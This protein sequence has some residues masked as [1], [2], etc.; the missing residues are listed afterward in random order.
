MGS[1]LVENLAETSPKP[2][3]NL[4]ENRAENLAENLAENPAENPAE[5][6]ENFC[7]DLPPFKLLSLMTKVTLPNDLP[8]E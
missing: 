1:C 3:R 7:L 2:R 8:W 4:A 6:H 5:N